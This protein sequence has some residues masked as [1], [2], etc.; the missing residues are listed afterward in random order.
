M[1]GMSWI[2]RA[3]FRCLCV[4]GRPMDGI[5]P[6]RVYHVVGR[7]AYRRPAYRWVRNRWGD[8]LLISP[9]YHIDRDILA[10][11]CYDPDLHR[12]LER[13]I[14]PGMV[15]LDVGANLGEVALHMAGLA[16]PSGQVWAFE[17][18]S[19]PFQRLAAHVKRNRKQD[20]VRCERVALSHREGECRLFCPKP[21]ADNQGLA[22][23]VNPPSND[24]DV[25][26]V[27][28]TTLDQFV[29]QRRLPSVDFVK[30]D[31]QGAEHC[32]LSGAGGVLE[33]F[34]PIMVVEVSGGDLQAAGSD[35][36][37]LCT[38]VAS[39]GYR[40]FRLRRNGL[41]SQVAPGEVPP[42]WSATNIVCV[43]WKRG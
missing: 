6:R 34:R 16:G 12:L 15:C 30:M 31:V 22:S 11:G 20:I 21:Q 19:G 10:F 39:S 18:A 37:K 25:E 27:R 14:E 32:I 35:S 5:R 40:L 29:A 7:R 28:M 26:V 41:G 13:T 23:I 4:V 9:H 36:R 42:A 8:E 1:S 2:W 33:R 3:M 24:C 38:L 17:P 43:P